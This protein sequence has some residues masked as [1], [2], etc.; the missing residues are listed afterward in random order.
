M[1][2][3]LGAFVTVHPITSQLTACNEGIGKQSAARIVAV[4]RTRQIF[5]FERTSLFRPVPLVPPS[6]PARAT[7]LGDHVCSGQVRREERVLP[8][9]EGRLQP[10]PGARCKAC[11]LGCLQN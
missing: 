2:K 3:A 8:H 7:N 11:T 1:R 6:N 5:V 10:V 9:Q 4:V